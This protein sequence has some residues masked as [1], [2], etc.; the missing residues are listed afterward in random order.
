[1]MSFFDPLGFLSPFSIQARFIFQDIC[2]RNIGWDTSI[3]E[4]EF[5]VWKIWLE[6]IPHIATIKIQRCFQLPGFQARSIELHIFCDA[7][8]RAYGA[9]AYWRFCDS[10]NSI[11]VAFIK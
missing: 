6:S 3:N 1:M 5:S 9:L 4:S 8:K 11:H 7:T 10:N 2:R